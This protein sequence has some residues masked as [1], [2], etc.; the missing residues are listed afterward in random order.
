MLLCGQNTLVINACLTALVLSSILPS[1]AH[2]F[3]WKMSS[4]VTKL[5][6]LPM[7]APQ[8][9]E[10]S[11]EHSQRL[12][13]CLQIH[14]RFFTHS[15]F[16][17]IFTQLCSTSTHFTDFRICLWS[18]SLG[19]HHAQANLTFPFLLPHTIWKEERLK[20]VRMGSSWII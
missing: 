8:A 5:P 15:Y 7:H 10:A 14:F 4:L 18:E 2:G 12:Q 20:S 19:C 17:C 3:P 6:N 13:Q 11:C 16:N 1:F 9:K